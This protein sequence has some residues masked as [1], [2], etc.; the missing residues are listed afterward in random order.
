MEQ[1]ALEFGPFRL[2]PVKRLLW[3]Q[4]ELVAVAPKAVDLLLA[5]VEQ[6]GD[7]VGKQELMDRVWPD[8]FV[9][10]ANLSVNVAT[11]RKV[12]GE[13][14]DGEPYIATLSR[15]GYRFVAPVKKLGRVQLAVLPFRSIGPESADG[16]Y[17]GV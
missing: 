12:L 7:V 11:L 2:D 17:L 6:A 16:P 9:E 14:A 10:E 3:R 8:S 13:R 1:A 15:R 5:L 4:G